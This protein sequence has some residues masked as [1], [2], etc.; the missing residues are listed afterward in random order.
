M[1]AVFIYPDLE[2][3]R[4]LRLTIARAL[5]DA[6]V[7]LADDAMT[8]SPMLAMDHPNI[9]DPAGLPIDG[10][11]IAKPATFMLYKQGRHCVI[12]DLQ[13]KQQW[14]LPHGRCVPFESLK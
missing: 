2:T 13:S 1:P 5:N 11:R 9:R 8:R 12:I 6:A 14:T 3:H 7:S 10:R 4:E